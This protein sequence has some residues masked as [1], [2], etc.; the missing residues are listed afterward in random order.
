[1]MLFYSKTKKIKYFLDKKKRRDTNGHDIATL[2]AHVLV[3]TS[4]LSPEF[5]P[6]Q[7]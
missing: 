6:G 5:L 4:S 7:H 1:M 3:Y 2:H